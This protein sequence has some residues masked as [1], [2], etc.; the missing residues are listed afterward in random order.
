MS[1]KAFPLIHLLSYGSYYQIFQLSVKEA[2]KYVFK[3]RAHLE[4]VVEGL[5]AEEIVIEDDIFVDRLYSENPVYVY[6]EER[7]QHHLKRI[8]TVK[9]DVE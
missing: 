2:E 4:I 1:Y 8:V 7:Q 9:I 6:R 5:K 3:T